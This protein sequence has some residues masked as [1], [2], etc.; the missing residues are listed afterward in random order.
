[1]LPFAD[2]LNDAIR[3]CRNPV[4]VGLDP[5]AESLPPGLLGD[6]DVASAGER[7]TAGACYAMAAAYGRFCRAVI[8]VVAPLVPAVK[9][10]AAFFEELGPAGMAV[11]GEV[12]EFARQKGLLVIF[13]GK[14]NDI[15]S[16]AVAY[17]DG[18]LVPARA[19]GAPTP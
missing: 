6:A 10:Q 13:D 11:L 9:P 1:M 3:R 8:D 19:P 18:I 15:G 4:V 17:A 12:I 16:T 7:H 2:R 14:R 5:R